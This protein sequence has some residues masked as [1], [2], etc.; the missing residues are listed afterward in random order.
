MIVLP[1]S[2]HDIGELLSL[3]HHEQTTFR[4]RRGYYKVGGGGGGQ[5]SI[6][7]V[8]QQLRFIS[9]NLILFR[10][11][12]HVEVIHRN[13]HNYMYKPKIST[14]PKCRLLFYRGELRGTLVQP[15]LAVLLL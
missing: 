1:K 9:S 2:T 7:L 14:L 6:V 10:T 4:A 15:K 13:M 5:I 3:E 12:L 11:S 8:C